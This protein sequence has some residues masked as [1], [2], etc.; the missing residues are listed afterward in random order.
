MKRQSNI[1]VLRIIAMFMIVLHHFM[2]HGVLRNAYTTTL[3]VDTTK[4]IADL[5]ESGGKLG[6]DIFLMISGYFL[7]KSTPTIKKVMRLLLQVWF[8]AI[9]FFVI[10]LF[11][12]IVP[13]N[14]G[15]IVS[16]VFPFAYGLY[17]FVTAYVIIYLFAPFLNKYL[18]SIGKKEFEKLLGLLILITIIIPTF[19]PRSI[20]MAWPLFACFTFYVTGAYIRLFISEG[21]RSKCFGKWLS[22]IMSGIGILT[23]V[24][25][26]LIGKWT[27]FEIISTNATYFMLNNS[28]IVIYLLSFGLL[29]W[30]REMDLGSSRFINLISGATFGV[31]LIHENPIVSDW[32]WNT[33]T[34]TL[35][36]LNYSPV[37]FTIKVLIISVIIYIVCTCIE[38]LRQSLFN[39]VGRLRLKLKK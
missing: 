4:I 8:Y 31:Y 22:L 27:G 3:N 5:C 34:H 39:S 6:V 29:I 10:N 19:L 23:V 17:W 1:E 26:N 28:S 15:L 33:A 7:I 11:L 32:L 21:E 36:Y 12:H 20:D 18:L 30:F 9:L 2:I 25:F 24:G 35:E 37:T 38:L 13:I 16:S 14:R